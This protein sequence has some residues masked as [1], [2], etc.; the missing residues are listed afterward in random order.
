MAKYKLIISGWELEA[1]A[2]SITQDEYEEILSSK[3]ENGYETFHDMMDELEYILEDYFRWDGNIFSVSF[4]F[5]YEND[6][7][8]SVLDENGGKVLSF[9][10]VDI[11]HDSEKFESVEREEYDS[12][13]ETCGHDYVIFAR[14]SS[15][16]QI[17][18]CEFESDEVPKIEDFDYLDNYINTPEGEM[19]ILEEIYFKGQKLEKNF[20]ESDTSGKSS[21][22]DIFTKNK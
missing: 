15:K 16:G 19:E 13:P 21:E 9:K 10:L 12:D 6:T 22:T 3:E 18:C 8:F 14:D 7:Y 20:D 17:Y 11:N 2:H 4:P 5:L 1:S